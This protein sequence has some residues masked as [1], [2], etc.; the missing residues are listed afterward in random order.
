MIA[1]IGG[2]G[3][4][5]LPAVHV[6]RR[7]NI[8][9]KYGPASD[10]VLE[11]AVGLDEQEQTFF[12]LPRHAEDHRIAP[13]LINYRANIWALKKLGVRKILAVNA[14]GGIHPDF[15]TGD[16][17]IPDQIIDYTFGREATFFDGVA[18]PLRHCD[19][20]D[21]FSSELRAIL[22]SAAAIGH[23]SVHDY[24]V[25]ACTQGPRLET[26]AEIKKLKND[27]CDLVGMTAM[28]EAVLAREMGMDYAS[29][30][31]LV[32]SAAGL[33]DQPLS[34][35]DIIRESANMARDVSEIL[36]RVIAIEK[37]EV[38]G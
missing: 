3:L 32:N 18:E 13:H 15:A 25:Y 33:G 21:P 9:S 1:V 22:V 20:S 29:I 38:E 24:G 6:N 34:E 30:C 10:A 23:R 7:H 11:V 8:T 36:I 31:M 2:T 14:V 12:F 37:E 26:A 5:K 35:Q 16:L 19:F 17:V 4:D 27:G 28:P